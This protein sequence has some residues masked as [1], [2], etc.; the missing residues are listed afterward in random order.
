MV[1]TAGD[2]SSRG[3]RAGSMPTRT[4]TICTGEVASIAATS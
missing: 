3:R 4:V 1:D 2:D